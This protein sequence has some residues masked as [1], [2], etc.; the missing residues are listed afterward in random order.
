MKTITGN[1]KA[2]AMAGG[3]PAAAI[4][5]LQNELDAV[6]TGAVTLRLA[7]REG[8]LTV[9]SVSRNRRFVQGK[10]AAK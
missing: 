1:K 9:F 5:E 10:E 3:V 4:A 8:V 6:H 7:K 2:R